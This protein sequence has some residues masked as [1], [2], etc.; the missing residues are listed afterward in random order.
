[1]VNNHTMPQE[2]VGCACYSLAVMFHAFIVVRREN[3]AVISKTHTVHIIGAYGRIGLTARGGRKEK[4]VMYNNHTMLQEDV[5]CECYSLA[6][7][8][9]A[10]PVVRRE[11]TAVISKTHIPYIIGA[12]GRVGLT[13]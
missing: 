7:M 13:L 12:R 1:M 5:G 2:D 10:L 6:V 11:N 3:T 4:T 9:H 8:F